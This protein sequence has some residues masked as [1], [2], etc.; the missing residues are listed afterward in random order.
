MKFR[1]LDLRGLFDDG[2]SG[3]YQVIRKRNHVVFFAVKFSKR[4]NNKIIFDI[5]ELKFLEALPLA[6]QIFYCSP[7]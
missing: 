1:Y 7:L 4:K 6:S 2:H 3:I 5:L